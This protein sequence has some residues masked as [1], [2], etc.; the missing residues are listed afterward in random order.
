MQLIRKLLGLPLPA[1]REDH[2]DRLDSQVTRDLTPQRIDAIMQAANSGDVADQCRLCRE[3]LE[4][5]FDIIQA[6]QTRKDALL[7]LQWSIE[8]GDETP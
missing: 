8:P 1:I 3:I 5:N 2:S 4:K 6:V 7:G